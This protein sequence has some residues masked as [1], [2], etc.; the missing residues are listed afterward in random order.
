MKFLQ[1][2]GNWILCS[3]AWPSIRTTKRKWR[4]LWTRS[5]L[6]SKRL[7]HIT[8]LSWTASNRLMQIFFHE[9]SSLFQ[10][11]GTLCISFVQYC[12]E[13][14][15]RW[16]ILDHHLGAMAKPISHVIWSAMARKSSLGCPHFDLDGN[17]LP[18]TLTKL[19]VI[20]GR[21]CCFMKYMRSQSQS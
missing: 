19:I 16:V 7:P 2:F 15:Q 13:C 14:N 5:R 21:N 6:F 4:I 18:A 20:D 9:L 12:I 8:F 10:D 3:L 11:E 1:I 17:P